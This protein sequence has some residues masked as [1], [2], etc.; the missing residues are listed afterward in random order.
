MYI[1]L[2]NKFRLIHT[3]FSFMWLFIPTLFSKSGLG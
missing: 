2:Y 1:F 3:Q